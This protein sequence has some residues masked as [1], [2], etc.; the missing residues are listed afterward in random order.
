MTSLAILS[1]AL[2]QPRARH[3]VVILACE[4]LDG[5]I[6]V[7]YLVSPAPQPAGA[8]HG[9]AVGGEVVSTDAG[10]AVSRSGEV[11]DCTVGCRVS[12]TGELLFGALRICAGV[13]V[14]DEQVRVL[15][16]P[17]PTAAGV[18]RLLCELRLRIEH[19]RVRPGRLRVAA[20]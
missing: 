5:Q 13:D 11:F 2:A 10:L 8:L 1:G 3:Q 14:E 7:E 6:C 15:F 20:R 9:D 4:V 12:S 16:A 17:M 19:G 18:N